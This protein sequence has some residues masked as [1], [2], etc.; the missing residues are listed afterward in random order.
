MPVE[1]VRCQFKRS[2]ASSTQHLVYS[3]NITY[4]VIFF[5]CTQAAIQVNLSYNGKKQNLRGST[6]KY[7]ASNCQMPVEK[8]RC[9]FKRSDASSTQHLVYSNNISYKVIF[10]HSTQAAIQGNLSY[11]G[12]KQNL[13]G[14][15]CKYKA[16]NCQMPVQQVRCQFNSTSSLLKQYFL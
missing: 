10:F 13:R 6:S 1:K 12:E 16:S 8:V 3:N 11:N 5:Y 15:T 14:S 7:K 2:D 9:Q 4:K